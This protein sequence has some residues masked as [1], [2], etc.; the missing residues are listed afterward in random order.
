MRKGRERGDF[1]GRSGRE[2]CQLSL[3]G[4]YIGD[5]FIE[6]LNSR[7]LVPDVVLPQPD[8]CEQRVVILLQPR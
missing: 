7:I 3:V 1:G 5:D 2:I 8:F 4:G 6:R